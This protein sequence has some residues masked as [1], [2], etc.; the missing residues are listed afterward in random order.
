MYKN[1]FFQYGMLRNPLSS[2][3]LLQG[4]QLSVTGQRSSFSLLVRGPCMK[5]I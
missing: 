1:L 3:N 4:V 2:A 5:N